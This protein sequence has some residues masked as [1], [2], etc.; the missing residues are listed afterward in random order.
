MTPVLQD[1]HWLPMSL[2]VEFKLLLMAYDA[3]NFLASA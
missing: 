2:Q 3:L 1:L